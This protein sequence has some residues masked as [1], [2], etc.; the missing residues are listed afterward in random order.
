MFCIPFFLDEKTYE[1][2]FSENSYEEI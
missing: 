2:I 1:G